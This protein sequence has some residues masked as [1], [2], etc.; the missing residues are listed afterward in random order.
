[1]INNIGSFHFD[2]GQYELAAEHY[3]KA[4]QYAPNDIEILSNLGNTLTK[5]KDYPHAW[6]AFEEALK[7]N[8]T[9]ASVIENYLL[10]LLE[11]KLLDRFE[12]IIEKNKSLLPGE[13]KG[14]LN[15]LAEE[16][17]ITLGIRHKKAPGVRKKKKAIISKKLQL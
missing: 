9:N 3:L 12:E 17:R 16:Y 2:E 6:L 15:G 4:L 14:K 7:I 1:M 13:T 11:A 8:P 5:L 10:C